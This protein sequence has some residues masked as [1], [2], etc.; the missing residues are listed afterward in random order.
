MA[1]ISMGHGCRREIC[2][3]GYD[4]GDFTIVGF[5]YVQQVLTAIGISMRLAFP[6]CTINSQIGVMIEVKPLGI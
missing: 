5:T 6:G 4:Y 3:L 1:R 2:C